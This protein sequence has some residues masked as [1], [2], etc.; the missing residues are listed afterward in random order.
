MGHAEMCAQYVIAISEPRSTKTAT[1]FEVD[2]PIATMVVLQHT[3]TNEPP[4]LATHHPTHDVLR[5]QLPSDD[6]L[7]AM[8]AEEFDAFRRFA[9]ATWLTA[10]DAK[11]IVWLFASTYS[12]VLF[13]YEQ[14]VGRARA[15]AT[16]WSNSGTS[17]DGVSFRPK[18]SDP[19][20]DTDAIVA[21]L[22]AYQM[23]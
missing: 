21:A 11:Q 12:G 17:L 14:P 15:T 8:S 9:E 1:G 13:V 23:K 3:S 18:A 4:L 20:P 22:G 10:S 16:L 7:R 2:L 5:G 6:A 19:C